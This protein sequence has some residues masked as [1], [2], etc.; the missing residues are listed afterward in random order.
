MNENET[1]VEM[2]VSQEY[3]KK[4]Q[5]EGMYAKMYNEKPEFP[6]CPY[7]MEGYYSVK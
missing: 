6:D 5:S 4:M 2:E 7:Y 1:K 3:I